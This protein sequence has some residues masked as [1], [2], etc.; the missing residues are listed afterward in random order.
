M[1]SLQKNLGLAVG[2][3]GVGDRRAKGIAELMLA[4]RNDFS[5][6]LT[7]EILFEWHLMVMSGI[8]HI[9]VGRWRT[10]PSPLLVVSG[11]MDHQKIHGLIL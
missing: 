1:S 4:T 7:S 9:D 5:N 2:K 3:E 10:D 8:R 11:S 6:H